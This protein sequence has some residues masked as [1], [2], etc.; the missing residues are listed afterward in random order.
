MEAFVEYEAFYGKIDFKLYLTIH[1]TRIE[2]N[3]W[4]AII[5]FDEKL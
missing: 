2:I 1:I 3:L 5:Y 4:M